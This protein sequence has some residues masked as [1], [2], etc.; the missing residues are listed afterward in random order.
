[1]KL[2]NTCPFAFTDEAAQ[3][4]NYGCLPTPQDII[5]MKTN[6]NTNWV[7][8]NSKHRLCAGFKETCDERGLDYNTGN[9]MTL[10]EWIDDTQCGSFKQTC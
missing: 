3:A 1:M 6:N 10:R 5:L 2:C 8:H 4:Q 7:C 9:R